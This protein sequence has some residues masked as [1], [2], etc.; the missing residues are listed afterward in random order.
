MTQ[1]RRAI[2]LLLAFSLAG[3]AAAQQIYRWTDSKGGVHITD[4]PPPSTARDVKS[5]AGGAPSAAGQNQNDSQVPFEVTRAMKAF[6]VVLYTSPPCQEPCAHARELLNRRGV[7][8][9]EVQV[10]DSSSIEEL[11]RVSGS[12]QVPVLLVGRSVQQGFDQGAYDALLDSARYPEAGS[13]PARK[14][15]APPPPEGYAAAGKR[16]LQAEPVKPEEQAKPPR[17][18]Y[19]PVPPAERSGK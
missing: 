18:P 3:P 9:R 1:A 2:A 8:F 13:V 10:W 12:D 7:P 15:A 6:P 4:T 5:E 19:A 11:K 14:Q 17:G 16:D